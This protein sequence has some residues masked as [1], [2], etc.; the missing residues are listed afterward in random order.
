NIALIY[1]SKR[2][3][4]RE[5]TI[6]IDPYFNLKIGIDYEIFKNLKAFAEMQNL[7]NSNNFVWQGYRERGIFGTIGVNWKF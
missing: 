6:E 5:N 3:T 7:T 1:N 4:N 2:F